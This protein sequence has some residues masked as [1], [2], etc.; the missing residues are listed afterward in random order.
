LVA[1]AAFVAASSASAAGP[2]P[3]SYSFPHAVAS[4]LQ[5]STAPPSGANDFGCKPSAA[6]PRPVVLVH[7]LLANQVDNWDTM[8]PLLADNGFC[9]FAFTYGTDPGE[10]YFG[11]LQP[12]EQSA[13]QLAEFVSRVLAATGTHKVDLVGHSEGTVMPRYYMEFLGGAALIDR[14]VM[15]TPIWHGTN[16]AGAAT[17]ASFAHAFDPQA[18]AA[19]LM[20]FADTTTC[21]S[22]SEFLTG[23][24]FLQNLDA[25]G[26][27]LGGVTYTDLVTRYD[28]LVVPYTSGILN[29][30]NVTN[31][32]IQ[33]QCPLDGSEHLTVAYDPIV[34]QDILNA[35]DPAHAKP[36]PCVPVLPFVGA[37]LPLQGVGLTP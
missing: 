2:Y 28:E 9:V 5:S 19:A 14:Y 23:S 15:M 37:P 18:A 12:M 35:L 33:D 29:A 36:V 16:V 11:G 3:V 31:I 30:P 4:A 32:T 24:P 27:A 1:L 22:C 20:L 6:H 7:G 21:G 26:M 34:G 17:I 10:A 8:A 25:H 13:R